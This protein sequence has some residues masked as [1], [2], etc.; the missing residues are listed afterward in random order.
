LS[1]HPRVSVLLTLGVLALASTSW[2]AP[3]ALPQ[4]REFTLV[5]EEIPCATTFEADGICLG[6]NGQIPGPTLDV[7]LGDTLVITLVNNYTR[8][9]SW[10]VHG[11]V[12]AAN[13]DG[14]A[15]HE[16]TQ[17][18][19]SIAQPGGSFT[20]TVRAGF[21]GAWHYHDHVL[22][23]D[24]SEGTHRGL[25][26]SVIVR[27]GAEQRHEVV[28]D[29]HVLDAGANGKRVLN[30]TTNATSFEVV[31]VGLGNT[32]RTVTLFDPS[33][34]TIDS[35]RIGPGMSDRLQANG[36]VMGTYHVK[37]PGF[38]GNITVVPP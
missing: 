28:Y 32:I 11:M 9:V 35:S 20:Y 31:V 17:L 25:Y 21:A 18:A 36:T 4:T 2:G 15:A 12:L 3:P 16:G 6:Y 1:V 27:N 30:V 24:G 13:M 26:G 10:H 34:S 5:A 8:A 23:H 38:T 37:F 33:G 14:V 22:G 19:E 29:V 7:N